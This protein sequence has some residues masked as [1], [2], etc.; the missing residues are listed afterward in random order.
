MLRIVLVAMA[1]LVSA[2]AVSAAGDIE[3]GREKASALCQSCHGP[4][5]NSPTTQFP[6]LGGQHAG[7]IVRALKD[8][9]SGARNNPI[10][11]GFAATLSEQDMKDLAAWYESQEGGVHTLKLGR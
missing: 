10:M 2:T 11:A 8:Y 5:G 9:K 7:Y 6:K 3:A 1:S 4:D